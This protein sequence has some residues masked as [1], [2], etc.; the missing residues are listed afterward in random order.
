MFKSLPVIGCSVLFLC[1]CA[2]C[3]TTAKFVY[4]AKTETVTNLYAQPKYDKV[5]A[6]LPF[7]E[8]RGD[9]NTGSTYLLY[10][11]PLMPYGY[12]T[13]E[14][15]EAARM[16]NTIPQFDCNVAEDFAKAA[17]TSMRRS[18]LFKDCFFSFGGDKD[19]ADFVLSG[20]V[21]TVTYE[22]TLYSYGVSVACPCL[23]LLGLPAGS[24]INHLAVK[25]VLRDR[26][27][28]RIVW[29]YA[30]DRKD[31]VVQGYYYNWGDDVRGIA[32]TLQHAMN[33]AVRDLDKT[34]QNAGTK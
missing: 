17:A 3:G 24:S 15:P 7:E 19:K 32:I 23:W 29:E 26:S 33:E 31:K 1:L 20:E 14:R 27:T 6:V 9:V 28:N 30:F 8:M 12:G 21:Y 11:V 5:L 2:G 18:G 34:L 25:L 22:G 13:Y 16:F 4:P 10:L